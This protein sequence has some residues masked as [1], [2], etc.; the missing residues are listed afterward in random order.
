MCRPKELGGRRCPQ[1]TDPVK[2][3]A[4][5]ARRRE[6]YAAKKSGSPKTCYIFPEIADGTYDLYKG[7]QAFENFTAEAAALKNKLSAD[8]ASPQEQEEILDAID[9]YTSF[10]DA[11]VRAHLNGAVQKPGTA[12]R[13]KKIVEGLEKAFSL[14]PEIKTPR[15][16]Y[17]GLRVPESI[18]SKEAASWIASNFPVGGVISQK[19][20]MSTTT[21]GHVAAEKF[22]NYGDQ[23]DDDYDTY[24]DRESVVFEILS[25]KGIALGEGVSA[26]DNGEEEVLVP[27]EARFKVVSMHSSK[28]VSAQVDEIDVKQVF[29]KTIIR[30]VDVTDEDES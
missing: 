29:N 9:K 8:S 24:E 25:T 16:L 18:P 23:F 14:A 5:N 22:S 3:S 17:R 26:F 4:Y 11:E 13:A 28:L 21:N 10:Y 12:E 30:L 19:N 6:L 1:H 15:L 20:Y 7:P 27:R 2:H